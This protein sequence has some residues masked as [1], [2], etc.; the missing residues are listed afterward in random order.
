MSEE[1]GKTPA[2]EQNQT[3]LSTQAEATKAAI[4]EQ[5]KAVREAGTTQEIYEAI[6]LCCYRRESRAFYFCNH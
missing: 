2:P 5:M 6:A 3:R 4:A 1:R